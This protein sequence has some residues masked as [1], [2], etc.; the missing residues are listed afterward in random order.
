MNKCYSYK[1]CKF[2]SYLDKTKYGEDIK[3][4]DFLDYYLNNNKNKVNYEL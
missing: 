3:G 4:N 1:I 2:A